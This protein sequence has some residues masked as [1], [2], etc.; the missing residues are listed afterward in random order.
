L[1][2][3]AR[4]QLTSRVQG[5][6]DASDVVQQTMAKAVEAFDPFQGDT[7]AEMAA[8]LRQILSRQL[9]FTSDGVSLAI[10]DAESPIQLLD[11]IRLRRQLASVGLDW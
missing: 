3:L 1:H 5:K 7:E 2:L 9:A 6:V 4:L 11:L 10:T 8:W